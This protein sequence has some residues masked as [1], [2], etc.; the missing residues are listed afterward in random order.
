MVEHNR[1]DGELCILEEGYYLRALDEV[2]VGV[3]CLVVVEIQL[4]LLIAV[5]MVLRVGGLPET[6]HADL[7][8]HS[9]RDHDGLHPGR[10]VEHGRVVRAVP[11]LGRAAGLGD[12]P[13]KGVVLEDAR[14]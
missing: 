4:R 11:V 13:A 5:V 10:V 14:T 7:V 8:A 1:R 6:E 9:H 3:L 12:E 2:A